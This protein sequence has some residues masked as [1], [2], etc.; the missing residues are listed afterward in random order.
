MS[1]SNATFCQRIEIGCFDIFSTVTTQVEFLIFAYNPE[2]IWT[3]LF[4]A[5]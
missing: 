5:E 4:F 1:V 2:Y 3:F